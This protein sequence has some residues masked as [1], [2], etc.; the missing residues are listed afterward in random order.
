[1]PVFGLS[2]G[3]I[4][5]AADLHHVRTPG[6]EGATV[7][8]QRRLV[9]GGLHTALWLRARARAWSDLRLQVRSWLGAVKRWPAALGSRRR[10]GPVRSWTERLRPHGSVPV[11]SLPELPDDAKLDEPSA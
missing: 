4:L 6:S 1:M 9:P 2:R 7:G 10:L 11:I 8:G 3:G 5:G